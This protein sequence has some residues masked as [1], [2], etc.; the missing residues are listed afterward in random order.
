MGMGDGKMEWEWAVDTRRLQ[1]KEP[2]FGKD[3]F[4]VVCVDLTFHR[5]GLVLQALR[6]MGDRWV[7][8]KE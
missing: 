2:F 1:G 4:D 7:G 5:W 8:L 3:C 6:V